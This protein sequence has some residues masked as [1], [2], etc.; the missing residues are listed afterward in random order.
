MR[1]ACNP[2]PDSKVLSVLVPILILLLLAFGGGFQ[3]LVSIGREALGDAENST[4]TAKAGKAA[5]E[6]AVAT[7]G[8]AAYR[9]VAD[10]SQ[11]PQVFLGVSGP[12]AI[13]I[14]LCITCILAQRLR[15]R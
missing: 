10:M 6:W 12:M 15:V 2:H 11:L 5:Q 9:Y 1:R 4:G 3:A 8:M 14:L 7:E 13:T